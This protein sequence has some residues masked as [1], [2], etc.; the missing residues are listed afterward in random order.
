MSLTGHFPAR[1][2]PAVLAFEQT[3]A[4]SIPLRFFL[5]APLLGIAVAATLA[6]YGPAALQTRWSAATF[7]ITHLITLGYLALI[8]V[9]AMI[10]LLAVV[11]GSPL[12]YTH[13]IATLVHLALAVWCPNPWVYPAALALGISLTMLCWNLLS[14]ARLYRVLIHP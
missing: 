12:P 7:A 2:K 5:T 9:G 8:M 6:Y 4:F 11:A 13:V 1:M 14:A 3:P 10:Q